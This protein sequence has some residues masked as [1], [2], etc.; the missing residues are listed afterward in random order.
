[1]RQPKPKPHHPLLR[2]CL[3]NT[4]NRETVLNGL[5][6]I[7]AEIMRTDL[8]KSEACIRLLSLFVR[9]SRTLA[10]VKMWKQLLLRIPNAR[11]E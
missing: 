7:Q 10:R 6:I 1:M 9:S 2:P 5:I 8:H 3:N 11:L 4:L